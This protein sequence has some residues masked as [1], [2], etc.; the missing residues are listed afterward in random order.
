MRGR[1]I[2]IP[3]VAALAVG[4]AYAEFVLD[5]RAPRAAVKISGA[6]T[7]NISFSL[8]EFNALSP[9]LEAQYG[10]RAEISFS[11][12][13]ITVELDGKILEERETPYRLAEVLGVLAVT[14]PNDSRDIFPFLLAPDQDLSR[15]ERHL[16]E[17]MTNRFADA[18]PQWMLAF[19]DDDWSIG[20]CGPLG[21]RVGWFVRALRYSGGTACTV[22]SKSKPVSMRIS[23]S[24]AEGD[25]WMRPFSRWICRAITQAALWSARNDPAL[26]APSYATCV[27]ADRPTIKEAAESLSTHLYKIGSDG[28]PAFIK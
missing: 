22:V 18:L 1:W 21:T 12:G 9:Q 23:V 19:T 10:E 16:A 5:L 25:P 15:I 26:P 13:K 8:R 28:E 2:A 6:F 11:Q 17:R 7:N 14:N 24:R 27:L 3:I 20:D 4:C